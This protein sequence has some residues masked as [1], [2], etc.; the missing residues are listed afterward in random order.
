MLLIV[1]FSI[2]CTLLDHLDLKERVHT[3]GWCWLNAEPTKFATD[4]PS[5]Q[6]Q[7]W[8]DFILVHIARDFGRSYP[9]RAGF[10]SSVWPCR[11]RFLKYNAAIISAWITPQFRLVHG[12]YSQFQDCH[13]LL[14]AAQPPLISVIVKAARLRLRIWMLRPLLEAVTYF[15]SCSTK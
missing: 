10:W 13:M 11:G 12:W 2:Y 9:R 8:I 1:I 7:L 14:E 5:R 6:Y 15:D 3:I 4:M